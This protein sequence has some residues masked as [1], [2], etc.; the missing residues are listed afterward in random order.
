MAF[1][2]EEF[3]VQLDLILR[4]KMVRAL[5]ADLFTG[6][7]ESMTRILAR[8]ITSHRDWL[9]CPFIDMSVYS[10]SRC[11]RLPGNTKLGDNHALC[12]VTIGNVGFVDVRLHYTDIVPSLESFR[13]GLVYDERTMSDSEPL[14]IWPNRGC[15]MLSSL[16]MFHS[17]RNPAPDRYKGARYDKSRDSIIPRRVVPPTLFLERLDGSRSISAV[18]TVSGK[19]AVFDEFLNSREFCDLCP[20]EIVFCGQCEDT[21]NGRPHGSPSAVVLDPYDQSPGY[22]CFNCQRCTWEEYCWD[23]GD[24]GYTSA[25]LIGP[26]HVYVADAGVVDFAVPQKFCVLDSPTGSGK[27]FVLGRYLEQRPGASVLVVTFRSALASYMANRL[28]IKSYKDS[29]VF[30]AG[31]AQ[32]QDRLAICL[33][34]IPRLTK[35]RYDVIV[36]DEG[37]ATRYHMVGETMEGKVTRVYERLKQYVEDADKVILMQYAL[38]DRDVSFYV[39]MDGV[40]LHDRD[41]V[42]LWKMARPPPLVATRYTFSLQTAFFRV[43]QYYLNSLDPNLGICRAPFVVFCV[44]KINAGAV[45]TLLR[46]AA[47]KVFTDP[48]H[49]ETARERIRLVTSDTQSQAWCQRFLAYPN[50]AA[51]EADVLIVT[52]VLQAGHSLDR[53]FTYAFDLMDRDVLT[54]RD[55]LQFVQRLRVLNREDQF[56]SRYMYLEKGHPGLKIASTKRLVEKYNAHL[57][58][59]STSLNLQIAIV[60]DRDAELHDTIN[61]HH[62]KFLDLYNVAGVPMVEDAEDLSDEEKRVKEQVYGMVTGHLRVKTKSVIAFF[63]TYKSADSEARM[64]EVFRQAECQMAYE[65]FRAE[66]NQV[67]ASFQRHLPS[68]GPLLEPLIRISSSLMCQKANERNLF[69][70]TFP[71]Y[72]H[73]TICMWNCRALPERDFRGNWENT[74]RR[75]LMDTPKTAVIAHRA[76][77]FFEVLKLLFP[78]H[79]PLYMP[80]GTP[81]E[82]SP[83]FTLPESNFLHILQTKFSG[84]YELIYGSSVRHDMRM[85]AD[86]QKLTPLAL[87]RKILGSFGLTFRMAGNKRGADGSPRTYTI[88]TDKIHRTFRLMTLNRTPSGLSRVAVMAAVREWVEHSQR[89]IQ[90]SLRTEGFEGP[91]EPTYMAGP[92]AVD[93]T[94]FDSAPDQE[95]GSDLSGDERLDEEEAE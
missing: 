25:D 46:T 5:Q 41:R 8:W 20:T 83:E 71:F 52:S 26:E 79:A 38:S 70:P 86:A 76:E 4:K 77:L 75:L 24:V 18:V 35:E 14:T 92:D 15:G 33:D 69:S 85:K 89:W 44:T 91:V 3:S 94:E 54:H 17:L 40:D 73:L 29:E 13:S 1:F 93:E 36:L 65:D 53:H 66:V 31:S 81:A 82:P 61:R 67:L 80:I 6:E 27:T 55:E 32:S 59:R 49:L 63:L 7:P 37:G 11:F 58:N 45:A 43:Y 23:L 39:E 28:H 74:R 9:H 30:S 95:P 34:S 60:A 78:S 88:R 47:A 10:A 12:P 16:K 84:V 87:A 57:P 2:A 64:V 68:A 50:G 22:Y 72:R 21:R 90:D 42:K 48:R 51:H 56:T 19:T 62:V